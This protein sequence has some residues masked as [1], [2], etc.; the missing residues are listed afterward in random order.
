MHS[1]RSASV[2]LLALAACAEPQG[3]GSAPAATSAAPVVAPPKPEPSAAAAVQ[4]PDDLD[5]AAVK[6]ALKCL[7]DAK[8]GPCTVLAAFATCSPWSASVPS[9]DGRWIGNGH[10]VEGGK[11]LEEITIVRARRV[12]MNEVG[13]GQLPVRIGIADIAK[14]EGQAHDQA[15]KLIRALA[16]G[17]VAAR[18]NMALEHVKKRETWPESFAMKTAGGQIYAASQGGGFI[19]QGPRQQLFLVRRAATRGSP[20]DGLYA[21]LW[22]VTW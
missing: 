7:P 10:V 17:D 20:G 3:Q 6:K 1:T 15:D 14:E 8:S 9:G 5:V 4:A 13:P 21:E 12:P 2:V 16:R 22:P 18:S 19:C 11:T